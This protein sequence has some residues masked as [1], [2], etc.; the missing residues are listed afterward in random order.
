MKRSSHVLDRSRCQS[1]LKRYAI[2][3]SMP[4]F[5][6]SC[7]QHKTNTVIR[8]ISQTQAV[9]LKY[10]YLSFHI[11][12]TQYLPILDYW[13]PYSE[14]ESL[15]TRTKGRAE[16]Y[17]GVCARGFVAFSR[18]LAKSIVCF[19]ITSPTT[20]WYQFNISGSCEKRYLEPHFHSH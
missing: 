15:P 13:I 8:F 3:F 19:E 17:M 9:L 5:P 1:V 14:A 10:S 4:S 18:V 20:H 16:Q 7:H 6:S 2:L 12:S 11:V